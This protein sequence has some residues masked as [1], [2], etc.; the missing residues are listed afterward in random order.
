MPDSKKENNVL[1]PII[2]APV[3]QISVIESMDIN[4]DQ[5]LARNKRKTAKISKVPSLPNVAPKVKPP[6][7]FK[8]KPGSATINR[9]L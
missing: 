6:R 4:E 9:K 2:T 7:V 3:N 5:I 1:P 8:R